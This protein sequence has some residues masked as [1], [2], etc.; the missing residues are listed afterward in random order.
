[1][2]DN[3][4]YCDHCGIALDNMVDYTDTHVD[5]AHLWLVADLCEKCLEELWTMI[6]EF[7]TKVEDKQ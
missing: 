6:D 4:I 1:M 3:T 5:I 2:R 7:C